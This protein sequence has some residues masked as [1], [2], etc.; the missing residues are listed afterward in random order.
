MRRIYS[1]KKMNLPRIY[2][3]DIEIKWES[4]LYQ[5]ETYFFL[6]CQRKYKKTNRGFNKLL[7]QIFYVLAWHNF[8]SSDKVKLLGENATL[9]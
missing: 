9:I 3:N 1:Q 5:I 6:S 8:R 4:L 7:I 2:F